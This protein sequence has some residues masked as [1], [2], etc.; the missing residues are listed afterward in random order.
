M[1]AILKTVEEISLMA[2]GGAK[3]AAILE[4]V[5]KSV[6]PG[7]STLELDKMAAKL[8]SE[9]GGESSFK[10]FHGYPAVTCVSRNEVVVHGIPDKNTILEEGDIVGID[11]G[12]RYEG[13]CTDMACT[14]PVG[15]IDERAKKLLDI[16]KKALDLGISS[17]SAGA[18][19]GDIGFA[20]QS[21]VEK[22]G[23]GLVRD[24]TGHGIG[25][26][27]HEEPSVPN[28]GK[29]GRGPLLVEGMVI[30]IEPMVTAGNPNVRQHNDGWTILT[31]DGSLSA[32][33]E[34]TVAITATGPQV[35]TKTLPPK[36]LD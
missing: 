36:T 6:A 26:N 1:Q 30:A 19:I 4:A 23:F 31:L 16:T 9:S 8:I 29:S 35:L 22:S 3:L 21:Y 15:K 25:R 28:F 11:I 27:P 7:L 33:F 32:H 5:S 34:H 10:G 13:Y 14:V 2:Q 24:L 12:L 17:A 18:H 20:I